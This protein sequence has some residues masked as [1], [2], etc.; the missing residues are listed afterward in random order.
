MMK[1]NIYYFFTLEFTF[2]KTFMYYK[3]QIPT[4]Q[5]VFFNLYNNTYAFKVFFFY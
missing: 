1:T 4:K 3:Y 2:L 5:I